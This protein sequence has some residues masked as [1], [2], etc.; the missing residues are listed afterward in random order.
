[1]ALRAAHRAFMLTALA[2][3]TLFLLSYILHHYLHGDV[4]YPAHAPLRLIYLPASAATFCWPWWRCLLVCGDLLLL[5]YWPDSAAP[6]RLP[7]EYFRC[8]STSR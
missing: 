7:L 2:F 3:S 1:M 8:G 6:Q 4:F 5:A